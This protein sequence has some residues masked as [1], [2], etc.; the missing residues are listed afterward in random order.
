MDDEAGMRVCEGTASVGVPDAPSALRRRLA[1]LRAP[2]DV[3]ILRALDPGMDMGKSRTRVQA[4]EQRRRLELITEPLA[5]YTGDGPFSGSVATPAALVQALRRPEG[6]VET[7]RD[8]AGVV[9]LFGA[10][11]LRQIAGPVLVDRDYDSR[12]TIRAVGE[13]PKS[14]YFWYE[15]TLCD[16]DSERDVA[17]M[18][19]MLRF[20]K[21]SSPL[22]Q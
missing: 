12:G 2:G 18:I 22:W 15:S 8:R 20:M 10:I 1:N 5:V 14:E 6:G 13:T 19:M 9:G 4:D 21:A 7:L 11:E 17:S 3:R 16:S